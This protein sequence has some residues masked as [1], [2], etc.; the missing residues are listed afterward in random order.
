MPSSRADERAAL[1]A[2]ATRC[3]VP[4]SG[5]WLAADPATLAARVTA[6]TGDASDATVDV[7][8]RQLALGAGAGNWHPIDASGG[9][10]A[11][12]TAA[13]AWLS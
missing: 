1:E 13:H 12:L 10:D 11:T 6:R 2:V 4:F 5:F 9:A 3:A 8:Q 7:L